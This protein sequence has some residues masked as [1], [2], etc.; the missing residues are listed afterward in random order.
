M[1]IPSREVGAKRRFRRAEEGWVKKI[2]SSF[3][4]AMTEDI[5]KIQNKIKLIP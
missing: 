5:R 1:K 3:L 2:A 4:L